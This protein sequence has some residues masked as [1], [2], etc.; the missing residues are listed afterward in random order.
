[1]RHTRGRAG[2]GHSGAVRGHDVL[3]RR[4]AQGVRS[5]YSRWVEKERPERSIRDGAVVIACFF[6]SLPLPLLLLL[7]LSF[8]SSSLSSMFLSKGSLLP[9]FYS[10]RLVEG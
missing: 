4:A 10:L 9:Q 1:M 2:H 3:V 6:C 8:L 5:T 7:L